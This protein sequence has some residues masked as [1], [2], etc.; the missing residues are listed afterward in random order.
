M[1]SQHRL[2]KL[3]A[4]Y[5]DNIYDNEVLQKQSWS[6]LK[7]LNPDSSEGEPEAHVASRHEKEDLWFK[8][9]G[10][11]K[12]LVVG[13]SHSKDFFN[14]LYL[15]ADGYEVARYGLRNNLA[16]PKWIHF[17][18]R[19]TLPQPILSWSRQNMIPPRWRT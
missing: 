16:S 8:D 1:L 7:D 17:S 6:I 3:D 2:A 15:N 9:A 19:R 14:G 18:P 13:N 12:I 10:G 5:Q 4:L 11:P